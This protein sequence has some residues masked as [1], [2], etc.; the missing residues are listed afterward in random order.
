LWFPL[1]LHS[2]HQHHHFGLFPFSHRQDLTQNPLLLLQASPLQLLLKCVPVLK[3]RYQ[4]PVA[5]YAHRSQTSTYHIHHHLLLPTVPLCNHQQ[6]LH[7]HLTQPFSTHVFHSSAYTFST[8]LRQTS[9]P[10][11]HLCLPGSPKLHS[12]HP[13]DLWVSATGGYRLP[14]APFSPPVRELPSLPAPSFLHPHLPALL[15]KNQY[16]PVSF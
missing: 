12:F 4:E 16:P 1:C 13:V 8:N 11:H 2:V 9:W 5:P 3:P 10:H 7:F 15:C 6:S 14:S